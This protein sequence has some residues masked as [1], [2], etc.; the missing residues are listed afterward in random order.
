MDHK[1]LSGT[2]VADLGGRGGREQAQEGAPK[3]MSR[4]PLQPPEPEFAPIPQASPRPRLR[5]SRCRRRLAREGVN[6]QHWPKG[7][8]QRK[9]LV[10]A[11][12]EHTTSD[13]QAVPPFAR[14][15]WTSAGSALLAKQQ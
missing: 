2:I 6:L 9:R 5:P 7:E 10:L 13:E 11:M 14:V 1:L 12:A 8:Q 3:M 15:S 4:Q